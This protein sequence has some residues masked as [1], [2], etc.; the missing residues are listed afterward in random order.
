MD[1]PRVTLSI[2][3]ASEPLRK[4]APTVDEHGNLLTDF[5]VIIPGLR[6]KPQPHIQRTIG[7]LHRVLERFSGIVVFAEFNLALNLLW[8]ST[9]PVNGMRDEI[10][11]AIRSSIP[12]ARLVSHV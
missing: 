7:E 11:T 12:A 3:D 6:K 5:M 9:R 8:V 10:A 2:H 1:L 4:R